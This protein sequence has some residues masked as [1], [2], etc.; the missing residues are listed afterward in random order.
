MLL[1]FVFEQ[2]G[3]LLEAEPTIIALVNAYV[4]VGVQMLSKGDLLRKYAIANIAGE[5]LF[6]VGLYVASV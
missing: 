5:A 6:R 2:R 3:V 1:L 4:A